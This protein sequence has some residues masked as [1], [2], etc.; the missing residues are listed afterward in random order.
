MNEKWMSVVG[1]GDTNN[2]HLVWCQASEEKVP[3]KGQCDMHEADSCVIQ[4]KDIFQME[5]TTRVDIFGTETD[6]EGEARDNREAR[7]GEGS[8]GVHQLVSIYLP[9]IDYTIRQRS[10]QFF[11]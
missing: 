10:V 11:F 3:R 6:G 2:V 1:V 8:H 9:H 5:T 4:V 7:K